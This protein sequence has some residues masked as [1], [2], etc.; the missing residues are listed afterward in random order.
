MKKRSKG[1]LLI[2]EFK[3]SDYLFLFRFKVVE[4]LYFLKYKLGFRE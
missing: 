1:G 3:E 4:I 2:L